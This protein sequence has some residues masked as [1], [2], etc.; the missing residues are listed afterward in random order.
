MSAVETYCV[1]LTDLVLK[2]PCDTKCQPHACNPEAVSKLYTWNNQILRS[3]Q[4][5]V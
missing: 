1:Y 3:S 2:Q 4:H 5:G